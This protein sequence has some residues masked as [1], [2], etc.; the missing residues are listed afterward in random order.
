MGSHEFCFGN[1]SANGTRRIRP[2]KVRYPKAND[3]QKRVFPGDAV[4]TSS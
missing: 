3:Q 2:L 4:P 1:E